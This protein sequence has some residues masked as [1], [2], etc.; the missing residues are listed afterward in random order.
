MEPSSGHYSALKRMIFR[1]IDPRLIYLRFLFFEG[2][3]RAAAPFRF[4]VLLGFGS[5]T[6][7]GADI[8]T[9]S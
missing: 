4:L 5:V 6:N 7:S 8:N 9:E 3:V 2:R 1:P